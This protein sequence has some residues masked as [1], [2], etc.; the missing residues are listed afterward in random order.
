MHWKV[1][2]EDVFWLS[3]TNGSVENVSFSIDRI[4]DIK[5]RNKKGKTFASSALATIMLDVRICRKQSA[6][7]IRICE[8]MATDSAIS[9]GSYE[10]R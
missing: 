7:I 6:E 4:A 2:N 5:R 1:A 3:V 9:G 8:V 10:K